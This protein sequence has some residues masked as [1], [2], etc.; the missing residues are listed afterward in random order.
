MTLPPCGTRKGVVG[1]VRI[2]KA[3]GDGSKPLQVEC[4]QCGVRWP[5]KAG[6]RHP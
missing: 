1:S 6:V 5:L 2:V 3:R 4:T